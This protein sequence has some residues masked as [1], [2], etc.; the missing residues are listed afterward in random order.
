MTRIEPGLVPRSYVLMLRNIKY[1]KVLVVIF[2]TVLIWVWADLALDEEL[3]VYSATISVARSNPK[4][5]VTFDDASSVSIDQIVL[6]GPLPR[7]SEVN[8]KLEQGEPLQFYFDA[9]QA[10]MDEHGTYSLTL[11]P[12]LQ[13]DKEIKRLGLKVE[14]CKPDKLSVKVVGLVKKSLDVKCFDED[15]NPTAATIEPKNIDISVPED[16]QGLIAEVQLT[17]AEIDQARVS[18]IRKTPYVR[19]PAGQMR[20]ADTTVKITMQ[21][22]DLLREDTITTPRL[23]FSL[24]ANLLGEYSVELDNRS[25][26]MGAIRIRATPDARRAYEKMAF[27][28]ILEIYDS[29]KDAKSAEPLRRKLIYN[30]PDESLR[31]GEIELNQERVEARFRLIKLTPPPSEPSVGG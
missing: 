25:D 17:P 20:R 22:T 11:L 29:D 23:G 1:G 26:V 18:A 2:L 27:Q 8:R 30:F 4:L 3:P 7:I 31:E 6:K 14:S 19:L 15:R 12:F 16:W 21:P 13:E 28:V 24:S 10:K 9:A 5:W